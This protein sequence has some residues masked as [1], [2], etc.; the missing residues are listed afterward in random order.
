M[1]CRRF[2]LAVV[3]LAA[4]A[5]LA[6]GGCRSPTQITLTITT[7]APCA[8]VKGTAL[9]V[10]SDPLS[11]E[12]RV[13]QSFFEATTKECDASGKIGTLVVT[14]G[15]EAAAVVVVLG[16]D[17][18]PKSCAPPA[19]EGCIVARRV[20][21]FAEHAS[22]SVPIAMKV[23]CENV[24]CDAFTT[25]NVG[26]CVPSHVDCADDDCLQPGILPDGAV[27]EASFR[28]VVVPPPIDGSV[29]LDGSDAA[30]AI[31]DAISEGPDGATSDKP[32]CANGGIKLECLPPNLCGTMGP[33]GSQCCKIGGTIS[34]QTMPGQCLGFTT[35][36][37][38]PTDCFPMQTCNGAGSGL[39]GVCI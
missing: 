19:Y 12:T 4:G 16:L 6:P 24:P 23:D 28:D 32:T 33:P 1:A 17:R 38:L 31:A 7:D 37:C 15:G 35:Y 3:L 26:R 25:C 34:C 2:V 14:P 36:C 39:A 8:G 21:G 22:L 18:D 30:D 10:G 20:V 13:K 29:P 5:V 11:T 27:D 9:T